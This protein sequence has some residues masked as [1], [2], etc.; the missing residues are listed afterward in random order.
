[1][2]MLHHAPSVPDNFTAH[3]NYVI[4]DMA[5]DSV[6]KFGGEENAYQKWNYYHKN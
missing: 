3:N 2:K 6:W 1:M 5:L 4:L